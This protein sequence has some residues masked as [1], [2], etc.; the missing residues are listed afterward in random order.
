M[1]SHYSDRLRLRG[2]KE[3]EATGDRGYTANFELTAPPIYAG[4]VPFAFTDF[5]RRMH[6]TP[7]AGIAQRDNVASAGFG[8]RWNWEKGLDVTVSYA[9]VL[10]GIAGGTPR[11]HDKVNFSLFYRF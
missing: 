5:G 9:N 6:I 8:A 2:L 1:N 4:I 7:V 10:N 11:G 3:R